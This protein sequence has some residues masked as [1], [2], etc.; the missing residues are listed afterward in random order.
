MH[1]KEEPQARRLKELEEAPW[2]WGAPQWEV[3]M[4]VD[5]IETE[6]PHL[7]TMG[8]SQ[9]SLLGHSRRMS[10]CRNMRQTFPQPKEA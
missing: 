7:H 10:G 6:N 5:S 4:V 9:S 2:G 8:M 1:L 3:M